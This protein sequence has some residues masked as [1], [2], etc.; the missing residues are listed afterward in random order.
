MY[1][2]A[3]LPLPAVDDTDLGPV[4][5]REDPSGVRFASSCLISFSSLSDKETDGD[6]SFSLF[7][8]IGGDGKAPPPT[9]P[10]TQGARPP[11]VD[12]GVFTLRRLDLSAAILGRTLEGM[13]VV[14]AMVVA[15]TVVAVAAVEV[16][17][18]G[19]LGLAI[20]AA[21]MGAASVILVVDAAVGA[22]AAAAVGTVSAVDAAA[23][24]AAAAVVLDGVDAASAVDT[25]AGAAAVAGVVV[26]N[27]AAA[28]E[29]T[30]MGRSACFGFSIVVV[31]APGLAVEAK[32][33]RAAVEV[34]VGG[35][36][37]ANWLP[38]GGI[39]WIGSPTSHCCGAIVVVIVSLIAFIT[40]GTAAVVIMEPGCPV[41]VPVR[42]TMAG[43]TVGVENAATAAAVAA[44]ASAVRSQRVVALA[45]VARNMPIPLAGLVQ[46]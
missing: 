21:A 30:G 42:L 22:A 39:V 43:L 16:G 10:P 6:A 33:E 7:P 40:A 12:P 19:A 46:S 28:V 45:G 13:G 4:L 23:G 32:I 5:M 29:E 35:A 41:T 27:A 37:I 17:A 15:V 9:P 25:A 18:V 24:V 8:T 34:V 20:S 31:R 44:A 14:A 3:F 26:V 1:G 36:A 11:V 38:E 2:E